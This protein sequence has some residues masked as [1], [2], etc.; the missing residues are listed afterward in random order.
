M[1]IFTD[2]TFSKITKPLSKSYRQASACLSA[3]FGRNL[4]YYDAIIRHPEDYFEWAE[5]SAAD[6]VMAYFKELCKHDIV[7]AE[8]L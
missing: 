4:M 2:K 8:Q 6:M 5:K 1:K 7:C 3:S